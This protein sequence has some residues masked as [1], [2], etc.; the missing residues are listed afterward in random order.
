M[1]SMLR[2]LAVLLLLM[3]WTITAGPLAQFRTVMGDIEVELFE[4]KIDTTANFIKLV[5]A[6]A[7][8]NTFFH[9]AIPDFVIQGGGFQVANP[10]DIGLMKLNENKVF[11]VPSLG[12]VS[13]EFKRGRATSNVYGTIAMARQSGLPNSA[14]TQWFFNTANNTFLDTAEGGYAVFG[15]VVSGTNVLNFFNTL[16]KDLGIVDLSTWVTGAGVF[17]DLPVQYYGH[18]PPRYA[19]LFYVDISLLNVKVATVLGGRTISWNSVSNK[20]NRVEFTTQFPP[21]WQTF[22]TVTGNGATMSVT[23]STPRVNR[24]FYR[25]RVDF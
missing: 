14:T 6:G 22:T 23:D 25:V 10:Q 1:K 11:V 15:K 7:Y 4:D 19:D 13:N 17:T 21:D 8:T 24:R 18:T 2:F 16:A 9:R 12:S 5:K 3:S 20:V